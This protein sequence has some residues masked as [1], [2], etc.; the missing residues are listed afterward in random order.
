MIRLH[1]GDEPPELA[2]ERSRRVARLWLDWLDGHYTPE[3]PTPAQRGLFDSGYGGART[4]LNERLG[5]KCAYCERV[6][7]PSTDPIDH[8][9]PR[10]AAW[11]GQ[12]DQRALIHPG[13]GWLAWSFDNQLTACS[14]CNGWKS[15]DFPV[16]GA[17]M[18]VWSVDPSVEQAEILDPARVDPT[19]HIEFIWSPRV[20]HWVAR[21]LTPLG[22]TT[23]RR[24][25]LDKHS[26]RYN[27]HLAD[28]EDMRADLELAQQL[29]GRRLPP[30]HPR[31]DAP[32]AG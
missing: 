11:Q 21:G 13:Y 10:R 27:G 25:R 1:R 5:H 19:R 24:L 31:L 9:R 30:A 2:Q 29:P 28:L 15:N 6:D 32:G 20:L 26:D 12:K 14:E 4:L 16:V 3:N 7:R 8:H 18:P 17:R 23:V 22:Q